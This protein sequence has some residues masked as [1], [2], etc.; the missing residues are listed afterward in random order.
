MTNAGSLKLSLFNRNPP[1]MTW[2]EALIFSQNTSPTP[3]C[4]QHFFSNSNQPSPFRIFKWLQITSLFT[5]K[6]SFLT[7]LRNIGK[8]H[9]TFHSF[10]HPYGV[11][12]ANWFSTSLTKLLWEFHEKWFVMPWN[13]WHHK[14]RFPKKNHA[15]KQNIITFEVRD[16]STY[17]G[18]FFWEMVSVVF[19][20]GCK[21]N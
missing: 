16:F 6:I 9:Q 10:H 17:T 3:I 21:L 5:P 14:L 20:L 11:C 4:T 18:G 8:T 13:C 7:T 15:I 19:C 2:Q 12:I 1:K